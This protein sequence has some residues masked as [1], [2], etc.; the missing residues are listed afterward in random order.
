MALWLDE[1]SQMKSNGTTEPSACQPLE[2]VF[3]GVMLAVRSVHLFKCFCALKLWSLSRL[4]FLLSL[5]TSLLS[6]LGH[7][8]NSSCFHNSRCTTYREEEEVSSR[9]NTCAWEGIQS[10]TYMTPCKTYERKEPLIFSIL[11]DMQCFFLCV[12]VCCHCEKVEHGLWE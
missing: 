10:D 9:D 8:G 5:L 6:C 7:L 1:V 12:C 3:A 4:R 11:W 2:S